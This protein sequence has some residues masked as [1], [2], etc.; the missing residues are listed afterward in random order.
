PYLSADLPAV[1]PERESIDL[2]APARAK[3]PVPA[4]PRAPEPARAPKAIDVD[5]PA[6]P[7]ARPPEAFDLD[8][9]LPAV[10][11]AAPR[12]EAD[13]P[14]AVA[15][16][17]KA[18]LPAARTP[19]LELDLPDVASIP[20]APLKAPRGGSGTFVLDLPDLPD[21]WLPARAAP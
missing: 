10:A 13:L 1:S 2:P 3:P 12:V 4:A 8:V 9:D 16:Q 18:P 7:S 21:F 6:I 17:A 19:G 15:R 11:G 5:L 14:A 20:A